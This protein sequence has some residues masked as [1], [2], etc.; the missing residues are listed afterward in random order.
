M[1]AGAALGALGCALRQVWGHSAGAGALHPA[2]SMALAASSCWLTLA[3]SGGTQV[4]SCQSSFLLQSPDSALGQGTGVSDKRRPKVQTNATLEGSCILLGRTPEKMS[5]SCVPLSQKPRQATPSLC[6]QAKPT[7]L[8]SQTVAVCHPSGK[9][10]VPAD[11]AATSNM[12]SSCNPSTPDLL[13]VK[14]SSCCDSCW[15]WQKG[16]HHP[17]G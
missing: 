14:H 11:I 13:R 10:G 6:P 4:L 17:F 1:C 15:L 2:Q 8:T 9:K 3:A 5:V 12:F 16:S 7:S